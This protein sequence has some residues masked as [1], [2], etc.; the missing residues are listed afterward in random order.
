MKRDGCKDP[1]RNIGFGCHEKRISPETQPDLW[2]AFQQGNNVHNKCVE[3]HRKLDE[4]QQ[5]AIRE[6]DP[7]LKY[8]LDSLQ[9]IDTAFKTEELDDEEKQMMKD[10][11]KALV[12]D[13]K[14]L[15]EMHAGPL[16]D[17]YD[18]VSRHKKYYY[19]EAPDRP[20]LLAFGTYATSVIDAF[21]K[22]V[23]DRRKNKN[24]SPPPFRAFARMRALT[25]SVQVQGGIPFFDTGKKTADE[26]SFL[27]GHE[28]R[29]LQLVVRNGLRYLRVKIT[30]DK[31][32]F[33]FPITLHDGTIPADT[34]HDGTIPADTLHDGIIPAD[35]RIKRVQF[36]VEKRGSR[37]EPRWVLNIQSADPAWNKQ[38]KK[39]SSVVGI[40]I[41]WGFDPSS[42]NMVLAS[43]YGTDGII[44]RL[45]VSMDFMSRLKKPDDLKSICEG[46]LNKARDEI[47][48]FR[49]SLSSPPEWLPSHIN[50]WKSWDNFKQLLV[51]WSDNRLPGD[52]VAFQALEHWQER[53]THLYD[54]WAVP[55][56]KRNQNHLKDEFC[57]FAKKLSKQYDAVGFEDMSLVKKMKNEK[58][59]HRKNKKRLRVGDLRNR[60]LN[61]M[62]VSVDVDSKNT[63]KTCFACK[64]LTLIKAQK[65]YVCEHCGYAFDRDDNAA[66]NIFARSLVALKERGLLADGMLQYFT[67]NAGRVAK[68]DVTVI[69]GKSIGSRKRACKRKAA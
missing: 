17:I 27:S 16:Q 1:C 28:M 3:I 43:A 23:V 64:E 53:H 10:H 65:H 47:V 6:L 21:G 25:F 68:I 54:S 11:R 40:D 32:W 30:R 8:V 48:S 12:A 39:V 45:E 49:K 14:A 58:R 36:I 19:G 2:L 26:K 57:K 18:E 50:K 9:E 41:N 24:F 37:W 56:T 61:K 22:S 52:S 33:E 20:Y 55:Q 67:S 66:M 5:K 62:S 63:T 59:R 38:V 4:A 44:H 60:I 31:R 35:A 69:Q 15:Q 51:T 13:R 42:G 29:G 7:Q 34:L 46:Y